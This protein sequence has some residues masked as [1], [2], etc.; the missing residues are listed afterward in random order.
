MN[1]LRNRA[2]E[3]EKERR[4][5]SSVID[6]LNDWK[7]QESLAQE[8]ARR[9]QLAGSNPFIRH[10]SKLRR[11]RSARVIQQHW[12]MHRTKK[13]QNTFVSDYAWAVG[14]VQEGFEKYRVDRELIAT[15]EQNSLPELETVPLIAKSDAC[16][17]TEE[18]VLI[19][20]LQELKEKEE[21]S[22]AVDTIQQGFEKYSRDK[23]VLLGEMETEQKEKEGYM[24]VEEAVQLYRQNEPE[25]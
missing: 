15:E 25:D 13:R 19:N 17:Q 20:L 11:E 21:L 18:L 12:S 3:E 7:R 24:I 6:S 10:D 14:M 1:E 5:L 8:H 2:A 16:T 23:L 22:W 4:E 9:L